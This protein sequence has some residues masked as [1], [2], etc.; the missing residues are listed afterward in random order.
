MKSF[1]QLFMLAIFFFIVFIIYNK[2]FVFNLNS[3][4]K[5]KENENLQS[6]DIDNDLTKQV[7]INKTNKD[8]E[9]NNTIKNLNY[10]IKLSDNSKY[11]INSEVSEILYEN[12]TE[13]VFMKDVEAIFVDKKNTSIIINADEAV[14]NS[15][16]NNTNFNKNI[17]I[18]YLDNTIVS[19]KVEFNFSENNILIYENVIFKNPR[20]S[21]KTDNIKFD[22]ISKNLF[23][24][25]SNDNKKVQIKSTQ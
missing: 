21:I 7:I 2:Y 20:G 22:L 23:M 11:I 10:E 17:N 1:L 15:S 9:G 25:M 16:N 18:Q 5:I 4:N 3:N 6:I 24:Y 8:N 12:N 19:E 14:Y 13:F